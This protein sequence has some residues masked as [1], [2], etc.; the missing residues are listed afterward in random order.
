MRKVLLIAIMAATVLPTMATAQTRELARDRR[1]IREEQ[2]ELRRARHYGDRH[3]VREERRDL[4]DARREYREDWREY[5]R[6][7]R[8]LYAR[9][10]WRSHHRYHA[11]RPGA[12]IERG[13]Y[14]QRHVIA[15]PWR[16]RLPRVRA[17]MRWVRHYDDVLLV[18][19]R[20]GRLVEVHRDFF[21]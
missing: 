21:W 6:K 5:R 15:D 8:H 12:R 20:T 9:G 1:E 3:D 19:M 14:G 10:D 4:R 16:Y 18:N 17:H 13:Y 7:H 11:F 2:R